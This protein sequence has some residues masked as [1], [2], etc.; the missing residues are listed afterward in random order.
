MG[1]IQIQRL[2]PTQPVNQNMTFVF[3]FVFF[4]RHVVS[5]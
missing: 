3:V 5:E 2:A 1:Q 4:Y